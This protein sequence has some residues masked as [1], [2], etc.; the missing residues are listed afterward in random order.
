MSSLYNTIDPTVL[1]KPGQY[2]L[3][4][5]VLV[6]Y[7]SVR[8]DNTAEKIGIDTMVAELNIYESIYNKTL[9]GDLL[10]IDSQNVVGK[11][12]LTGNERL[13]FKF[14][15]PSSPFGY[16]FSEK[17]GNPMYIYKITNRAGA[18]P[19]TQ[20]Y[21]ISFCSKEMIDNEL[22]V[23]SNAQLDTYS[24]MV[25]NITKNPDFL[26]SKKTLYYEPSIGLHKHVFSRLR[27][28]DC[29]D[30]LSQFTT[31]LKFHNA[32][33]YFYETS[34]GFNYRSLESM[35]AL[36]ANTARTAVAKFRPKPA[37][38][39]DEK[40]EK[41]ILNEMQVVMDYK[42]IDQFDTLKNLRNGVYASKL[43]THNQ[44]D[45]TYVE[46]DF[47]YELEYEKSF[48][49]EMNKDGTRENEKGILPKYIREGNSLSEYPESTLYLWPD[50]TNV[51]YTEQG[52][53]VAIAD[54]KQ[55]LQQRLSQRLA[56]QS[57]KLQITVNG[58]TALQAGDIITFEMPS[59]EPKDG[60][61]PTDFDVYMSGRYLVTSV[62]HQTNLTLKKH[63]MVLECMKDSVRR[64]YPNEFNDTFIEKEK[65]NEGI[66]DQY[67]FDTILIEGAGDKFLR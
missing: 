1:K 27:P 20:M 4:D 11:L 49:T 6:S 29:I 51:H 43:I 7:R 41:D 31:S 35:L 47:N 10:I 13:E 26:G 44:L 14:F 53:P 59:Y 42:I 40:G 46:T 25:S 67:E 55:I 8:G 34:R 12:P 50:T 65:N 9:S 3:T 38:I 66:I 63:I 17:S 22:K 57:F 30:Q 54:A 52:N 33:Y 5:V 36:E 37:N 60:T 64:P 32:G 21:I 2:N 19:K 58:F 28:F 39:S 18:N 45:K 61:E 56:F 24:S 62:R 48:H 16:D 15:T 23:V